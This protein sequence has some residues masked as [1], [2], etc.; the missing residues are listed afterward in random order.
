[1]LTDTLQQILKNKNVPS[2]NF[3]TRCNRGN[4]YLETEGGYLSLNQFERTMSGKRTVQLDG[5]IGRTM[6]NVL[7]VP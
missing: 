6:T 4:S 2:D 5:I 7:L 3:Y 1:M